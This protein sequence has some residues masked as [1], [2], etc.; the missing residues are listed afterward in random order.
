[1]PFSEASVE[2]AKVSAY[3]IPT[4]APEAD[5]TFRWNPL[6]WCSARSGLLTRSD[7]DI[8]TAI[9]DVRFQSADTLNIS[10]TMCG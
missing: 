5:G 9:A 3:A 4:N 10:I 6:R 2:R 1:M 8:P 7:V